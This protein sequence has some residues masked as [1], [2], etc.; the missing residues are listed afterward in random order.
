MVNYGN[1][2]AAYIF[3]THERAIIILKCYLCL[4][5]VANIW[6]LQCVSTFA[7]NFGKGIP[8]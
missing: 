2:E 3:R 1:Y 7:P 8:I 5:F 4:T 6:A